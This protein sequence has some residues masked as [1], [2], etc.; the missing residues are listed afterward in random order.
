MSPE[1]CREDLG[2]FDFLHPLFG[3]VPFCFGSVI[4]E[5]FGN[6]RTS[7]LLCAGYVFNASSQITNTPYSE[8]PKGFK[9]V[10]Q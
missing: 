9:E 2:L 6:P 7:S 8:E 10:Y 1:L 5:Q 3:S 4:S